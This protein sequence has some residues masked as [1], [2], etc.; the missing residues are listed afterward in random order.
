[1]SRHLIAPLLLI[2]LLLPLTSHGFDGQRKGF[3]VGFGLGMAPVANWSQDELG[4]DETESSYG[5]QFLAGYA[6]DD[7]NMLVYD[8]FGA[9]RKSS[10]YDAYLLQNGER[11]SWY[12]YFRPGAQGLYTMVGVGRMYLD[13]ELCGVE[14][15]GWH[16]SFGGGYEFVKQVQVGAYY[17]GGWTGSGDRRFGHHLL[18]LLVTV[19]AY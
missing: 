5:I 3:V 17:I 11:I 18:A 12:H 15:S 8:G 4:I 6:W 1:M 13:S 19:V 14:S 9:L 10:N 7:R 2:G 16:I